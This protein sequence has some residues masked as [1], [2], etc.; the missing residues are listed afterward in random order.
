ML[1]Y[2]YFWELN[3]QYTRGWV[4][5]Y[6]SRTKDANFE[7]AGYRLSKQGIGR[8]FHKLGQYI[9]DNFIVDLHPALRE[10]DVFDELLDLIYGRIHIISSYRELYDSFNNFPLYTNADKIM[11]SLF[12]YLLSTRSRGIR[13]F[14]R[15]KFYLE[16]S[17]VYFICKTIEETQTK[18]RSVYELTG[19]HDL[20]L[21]KHFCEDATNILL[22]FLKKQPL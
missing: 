10:E 2:F 7:H 21:D 19:I 15:E 11:N 6:Y 13:G 22:K 12:F 18:F 9:W 4:W 8:Y 16:F 20:P 3:H 14:K 1:V 17:R 5:Y